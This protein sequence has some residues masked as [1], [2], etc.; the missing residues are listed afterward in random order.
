[1]ISLFITSL[2]GNAGR[3]MLCA[4]L[5]KYWLDSGKKVGYLKPCLPPSVAPEAEDPDAAFIHKLFGLTESVDSLTP[6]VNTG[7]LPDPHFEQAY[8]AAVQDKE[9]IIIESDLSV[10]AHL[11]ALNAR[12]L[13]VHDFAYPLV[14]S[15]NRYREL[16][17]RLLG[18][19]VNKVPRKDIVRVREKATGELDRSG[20][21]LLGLI[22]EDRILAAL[23]VA[24]LV[25]AVHGKV[26]NNPEK[27]SGL[28]ENIMLGSSTFDRGTAYYGRKENKAVL[29]WGERPGFRKAALSNLQLNAL[30]TSTR[31]L[32]ISSNG[33][34]IPAVLQKAG[35]SGVP[36]ISAPGTLPEIISDIEAAFPGSDSTMKKNASTCGYPAEQCEFVSGRSRTGRLIQPALSSEQNQQHSD[37][38]QDQQH[39]RPGQV[40]YHPGTTPRN[41]TP[42]LDRIKEAFKARV[43]LCFR[44]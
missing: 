33:L 13:V 25:E 31:C 43:S 36:L 14:D 21:P 23:S 12:V 26:L 4:G 39:G 28:I 6:T 7:N 29:L 17:S 11:A 3:T 18:V 2:S 22:P 32:V 40:H 15:F 9:I 20:I 44:C 35:E 37:S 41:S 34:P 1:M 8:Q 42:R 16:G 24:D 38:G 10:V 30:Q 19:I 5:G 27:T